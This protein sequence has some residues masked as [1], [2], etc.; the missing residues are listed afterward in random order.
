MRATAVALLLVFFPL[1]AAFAEGQSPLQMD[2]QAAGYMSNIAPYDATAAH[3]FDDV[4]MRASYRMPNILIHA[5]A[6]ARNDGVYSPEET[7]MIGHHLVM[8]DAFIG[9]NLDRFSLTAGRYAHADIVD[10][11]YSLF[12]SPRTAPAVAVD[13]TYQDQRFYYETRWVQ[14]N[15]LSSIYTFPSTGARLDRGMNYKVYGLKSGNVRFGLQDSIVYVGRSFDAE[16]FLNPMFQYLQQLFTA[17][18]GKPWSMYGNNNCNSLNGFFVDITRP[19]LYA[20]AQILIDDVNLDFLGFWGKLTMPTKM[21]WSLGGHMDFPFGR[22]GAYTAG[23][24]KYTFEAT[25]ANTS[26]SDYPYEYAYYPASEYALAGGSTLMTLDY[27]DNY[28]GYMYGENTL[29][30]LVDYR[31]EFSSVV[32]SAALEYVVSGS[33]SPSNPWHEASSTAGLPWFTH[34]PFYLLEDPQLEHTVR[35]TVSGSFRFGRFDAEARVMLGGRWNSLQL[36]ELVAG[37]PKIFQ[38]VGPDRL[39]CEVRL[40]L[41]W[42]LF[43]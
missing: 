41:A 12:I 20:Y 19:D 22:L 11:P 4:G 43:G 40:G 23:A 31:R 28:I 3:L 39:L 14:L 37:E 17:T 34:S 9:L 38:P 26:Y 7:Y 6:S 36:V 1:A 16:Y 35:G 32:L 29:S 25:Y 42:H 18:E 33:K 21:A 2:L 5:E 10:S 24:T 13:F 15:T 30:F 27:A 8:K